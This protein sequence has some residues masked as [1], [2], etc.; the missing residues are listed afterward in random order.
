MAEQT[1][2]D[3]ILAGEIPSKKVYEDEDVYAFHDIEPQAPVHVLVIPK[4]KRA[5]VSELAQADA[6]EAGRFLAGVARVAAELDLENGYRVVMNT[7]PDA[8]QSVEY[9]HAHIIGGRKLGWPPG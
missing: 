1:V 8:L 3:K 2:F 5:N 4:R 9:V 7:G 6:E